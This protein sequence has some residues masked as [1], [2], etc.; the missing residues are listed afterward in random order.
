MTPADIKAPSSDEAKQRLSRDDARR[1]FPIL[2]L[3]VLA[4][5]FTLASSRFLQFNNLMIVAQ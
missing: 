1:L 3:L 2:L 4:A 5:A